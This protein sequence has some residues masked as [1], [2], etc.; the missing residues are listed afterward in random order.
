[1]K[2]QAEFDALLQALRDEHRP[3][4]LHQAMLVDKM[5]KSQWQL[6]RAERLETVALDLLAMPEP[7]SIDADI[8]IVNAMLATGRDALTLFKRYAAEAERSYYRASANSPP[9]EKYRTKP[10]W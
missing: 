2:A 8:R 5:A 1:M 6:A 9:Q 3:G 10:I 7:E 4:G